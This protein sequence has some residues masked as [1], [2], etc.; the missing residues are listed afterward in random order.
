MEALR[1]L[2]YN[3]APGLFLSLVWKEGFLAECDCG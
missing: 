2:S 3:C 1:W